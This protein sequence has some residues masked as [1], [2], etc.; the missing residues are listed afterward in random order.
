[1]MDA[2][3]VLLIG[4]G[5]SVGKTTSARVIGERLGVPVLEP[6]LGEPIAPALDPLSGPVDLWDLP[7]EVLC[8]RLIAAAEAAIPRIRA[9]LDACHTGAIIEGER[10]HPALIE[11][12]ERTGR[13]RGV[14]IIETDAARLHAT[15]IGRSRRFGELCSARQWRV[16]ETDAQYGRWLRAEAVRRGL[17]IVDSQPFATLADRILTA[18]TTLAVS[19][20]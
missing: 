11:T 3:G 6:E 8:A 5:S 12:M 10:V 2:P 17:S 4:G 9:Q 14:L 19:G 15:L 20:T 7:A 18:S 13:A 16:A 1:M